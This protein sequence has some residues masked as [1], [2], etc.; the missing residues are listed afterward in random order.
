MDNSNFL[1][2]YTSDSMSGYLAFNGD[3]VSRAQLVKVMEKLVKEDDGWTHVVVRNSGKNEAVDFMY[4]IEKIARGD[5]QKTFTDM[6]EKEFGA[7]YLAA[8]SFSDP[9]YVVKA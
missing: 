9:A 1:S 6:F 4:K 3:Y 5:R 7:N 2:E 8:W